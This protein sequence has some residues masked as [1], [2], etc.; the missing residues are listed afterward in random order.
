[1]FEMPTQDIFVGKQG[2]ELFFNNLKENQLDFKKLLYK[3]NF[4]FGSEF[5]IRRVK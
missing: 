1:M 5:R 4:R 2:N 3:G